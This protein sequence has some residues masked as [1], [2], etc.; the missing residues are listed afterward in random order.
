[1]TTRVALLLGVCAAVLALAEA[2]PKAAGWKI[3][4]SGEEVSCEEAWKTLAT[5]FFEADTVREGV[6]RYD[7]ISFT[8]SEINARM[9]APV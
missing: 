2:S 4:S 6:F 5:A 9:S 1:M 3:N 7:K 8:L